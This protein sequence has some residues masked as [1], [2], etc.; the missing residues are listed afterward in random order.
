MFGWVLNTPLPSAY[1]RKLNAFDESFKIVP[2]LFL[3]LFF[4]VFFGFFVITTLLTDSATS[5]FLR[6]IK[7]FI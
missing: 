2:K 4:G 1:R 3:F 5:H 7:L 6:K